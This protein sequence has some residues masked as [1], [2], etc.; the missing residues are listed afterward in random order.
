M[1]EFL[2]Y[3]LSDLLLFSEDTFL[4]QF[5]LFYLWLYPV[6]YLAIVY[7]LAAP[8]MWFSKNHNIKTLL[9]L[10]PALCWWIVAYG[11][12]W[13]FYGSINWVAEYFVGIFIFQGFLMLWIAFKSELTIK[14]RSIWF[15]SGMFLWIISFILTPSL[16]LINGQSHTQISWF[17]L[18]PDT[19]AISSL[20]LVMIFNLHSFWMIPA[21]L[22]LTL[23][24][25]TYIS[26]HTI[27]MIVPGLSLVVY[28]IYIIGHE[29]HK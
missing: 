8:F 2:S 1:Q 13:Q 4:R 14:T 10:F 25:L 23:S 28:F 3:R 15:Y 16:E 24:L 17:I 26:L 5:E 7:G 6:Q 29:K 9:F 20:A 22:W 12:L 21:L 18:S 27:E 19:L 11:Y